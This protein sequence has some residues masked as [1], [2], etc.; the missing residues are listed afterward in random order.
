M[1]ERRMELKA[2]NV[3]EKAKGIITESWQ[4]QANLSFFLLLLVLIAF[5]LPSLGFGRDDFQRYSS[6]SFSILLISGVAIA[7]GQ[8]KL[9]LASIAIAAVA[10]FTRVLQW[11][12]P[13]PEHDLISDASTLAA[14][15]V[16]ALVLLAQVFRAGSVTPARLQGAIAA[17]LLFGT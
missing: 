3:R 17:Y 5:V 14:I 2:S 11:R 8:R 7:W 10:L 6:I 12:W 13:S 4:S 15:I 16:I 1:R 9:F